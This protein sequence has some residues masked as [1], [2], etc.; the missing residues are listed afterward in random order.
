M[1]RMMVPLLCLDELLVLFSSSIYFVVVKNGDLLVSN[2]P[3]TF[4]Y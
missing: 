4:S 1:K 2:D 3:E